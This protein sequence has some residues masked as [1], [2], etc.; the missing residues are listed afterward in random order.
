MSAGQVGGQ[1][2]V[3]TGSGNVSVHRSGHTADQQRVEITTQT[4]SGNLRVHRS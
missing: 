2:E 4:V 3:S 1:L